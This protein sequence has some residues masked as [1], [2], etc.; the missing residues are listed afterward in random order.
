MSHKKGLLNL[1]SHLFN[2]KF[3]LV[4]FAIIHSVFVYGWKMGRTM[5]T[6][7]IDY[8]GVKWI[9]LFILFNNNWKTMLQKTFGA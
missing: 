6:M 3:R 8:Y 9:F 2:I 4:Y 5:H 1:F 7:Q